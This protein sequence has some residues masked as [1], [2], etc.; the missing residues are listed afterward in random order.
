MPTLGSL[1]KTVFLVAVAV[2]PA[3]IGAANEI[4]IKVVGGVVVPLGAPSSVRMVTARVEAEIGPDA[5]KVTCQYVFQN[6]GPATTVTMGF[7]AF[8]GERPSRPAEEVQPLQDFRAW[9]DGVAEP[10]TLR[11][12]ADRER[13]YV[14]EITFAAGQRRVVRDTYVQPN[15]SIYLPPVR[16]IFPYNLSGAGSWHGPVGRLDV[17]L[18]WVGEYSWGHPQ[19]TQGGG[20][21]VISAEGRQL[22]RS[23]TNV[24]TPEPLRLE[25]LPGWSDL[26][27]DGYRLGSPAAGVVVRAGLEYVQMTTRALGQILRAQVSHDPVSKSTRI[28]GGGHK[29]VVT[30]GSATALVDGQTVTLPAAV[31]QEGGRQWVPVGPLL[32]RLGYRALAN[33]RYWRLEVLSGR[34]PAWEGRVVG[35][36]GKTAEAYLVSE[37]GVLLG[38]IRPLIS[39]MPGAQI[40]SPP[41]GAGRAGSVKIV[42][43]QEETEPHFEGGPAGSEGAP[44]HELWL[45]WGS[46]EAQLDGKPY[47]LTAAPYVNLLG[48][49][50]APVAALCRALGLQVAYSEESKTVTVSR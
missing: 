19:V 11:A 32:E 36:D 14:K 47:T 31:R 20:G 37:R 24:T 3:A 27:V 40:S 22:K 43:R 2:L 8:F 45:T 23:Q 38:E 39:V 44:A 50:M 42:W 7:P 1:R 33:H 4:S 34:P 25:F 48:R 17:I 13:W 15:G 49:G 26:R 18:R 41:P 46:T 35:P 6:E 16:R 28:S 10:T 9:V 30:T 12:G 5:S 21:W 29:L